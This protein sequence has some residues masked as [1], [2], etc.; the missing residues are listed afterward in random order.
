[1]VVDEL[2]PTERDLVVYGRGWTTELL[3]P[4]HFGGEHVPNDRLAAYYGGAKI[5]LN[6]H[7]ADMAQEGFLS[8]RLYDAAASGA[9]V[10]SDRVPGIDEEFDGGIVS[11]TDGDELREL[12]ERYLDDPAGRIEHARRARTAVL[13]RHTFTQRVEVILEALEAAWLSHTT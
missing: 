13:A 10:I 2:T 7:W 4:R 12:V 3:D 1:V 11:F 5:V 9:F 6:D 8:N